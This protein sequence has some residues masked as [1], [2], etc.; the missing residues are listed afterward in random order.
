MKQLTILL[1]GIYFGVI[2]VK[3]EVASWFR[4]QEMFLFNEAHMYLVIVSAIAVGAF[5]LWLIR[6]F[7]ARTIQREPIV[8]K[9][10][11]FQYGVIFGG[12]IF[13]MG[14]AITGACPGPIYAQI[15]AGEWPAVVTFVGAM[16]G[17]YGYAW[18]QPLL[19]HGEFKFGRQ[20]ASNHAAGS[21][22]GAG[23]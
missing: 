9:P 16:L 2:L 8:L 18:L 14:W 23:D 1:L 20:G 13:G 3:S 12:I 11:P 7:E 21:A 10:K 17:M 22:V 19:P 5:S 15:G 6:R 4:I